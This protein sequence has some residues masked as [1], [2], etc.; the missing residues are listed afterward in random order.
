MCVTCIV[1]PI[2]TRR[3]AGAICVDSEPHCDSALH[4]SATPSL[5]TQKHPKSYVSRHQPKLSTPSIGSPL[6]SVLLRPSVLALKR[7]SPDALASAYR[8]K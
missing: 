5:S 8:V 2:T 4:C 3:D 7:P 6:P 1:Y